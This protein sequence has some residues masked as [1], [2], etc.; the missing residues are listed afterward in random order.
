MGRPAFLICVFVRSFVHRP[1][2]RKNL[3]AVFSRELWGNEFRTY[4]CVWLIHKLSALRA[5]Y[6]EIYEEFVEQS[7]SRIFKVVKRAIA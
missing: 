4:Q 7:E 5:Q 6:P 2:D 3:P 1:S